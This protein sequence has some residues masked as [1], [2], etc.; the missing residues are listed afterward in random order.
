MLLCIL[1]RPGSQNLMPQMANC[2]MLTLRS[3]MHRSSSRTS[4]TTVTGARLTL[5][6]SSDAMHRQGACHLLSWL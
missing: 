6:S 5:L 1:G 3:V 4:S 2:S